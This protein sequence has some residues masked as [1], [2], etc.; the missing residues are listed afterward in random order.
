[1]RTTESF[2][3]ASSTATESLRTLV[4][5]RSPVFPFVCHI[6]GLIYRKF[7]NSL[8][9]ETFLLFIKTRQ[10]LFFRGK[11][12][13]SKDILKWIRSSHL[14]VIEKTAQQIP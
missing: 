1:M 8:E 5:P 12:V 9:E 3:N 14:A 7:M 10:L 6:L 11:T 2:I 13:Q 4:I